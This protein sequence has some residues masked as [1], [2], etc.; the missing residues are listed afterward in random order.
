MLFVKLIVAFSVSNICPNEDKYRAPDKPSLWWRLLRK[1]TVPVKT[2]SV[3]TSYK[4]YRWIWKSTYTFLLKLG[5][6]C[7]KFRTVNILKKVKKKKKKEKYIKLRQPKSE[8]I[9]SCT[10]QLDFVAIEWLSIV[11][12][13]YKQ[14]CMYN[15]I[16]LYKVHKNAQPNLK[17]L[18]SLYKHH[19]RVIYT[20]S[21]WRS[22]VAFKQVISNKIHPVSYHK[23]NTPLTTIL[24]E[25]ARKSNFNKIA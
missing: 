20:Y 18:Y 10:G 9:Y 13:T 22:W 25:V 2:T 23:H 3:P 4:Y 15:I 16:T 6:A 14:P 7:L 21:H 12:I 5:L 17:G 11:F 24:G 8:L 1:S 19:T